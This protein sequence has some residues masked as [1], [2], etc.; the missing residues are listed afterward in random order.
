MAEALKLEFL[1]P[2]PQVFLGLALAAWL[3]TFFGLLRRLVS[4]FRPARGATGL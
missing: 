1:D 2:I 4:G 3:A